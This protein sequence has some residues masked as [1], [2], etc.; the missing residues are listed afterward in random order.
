MP[1]TTHA[2]RNRVI[3]AV[4]AGLL[5]VPATGSGQDRIGAYDFSYQLSGDARVKPVHVFDDGKHTFFQFRIGE[6]V[7]AIFIE[8]ASGTQL[9][10]PQLEGPYVKV[11][12]VSDGFALRLGFGGGVHR[13]RASSGHHANARDADSARAAAPSG[14]H[15][16]VD[17]Y[18][19]RQPAGLWPATRD[20]GSPEAADRS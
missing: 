6:P 2:P 7:P 9:L 4:L 8:G 16:A 20:A 1:A 10:V 17:P 18:A 19:C 5:L 14:S 11:A 12:A 15:A 13:G 3:P